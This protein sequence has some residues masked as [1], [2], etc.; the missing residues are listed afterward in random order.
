MSNTRPGPAQGPDSS[1]EA[2]H[3]EARAPL[4]PYEREEA[5]QREREEMIALQFDGTIT[6]V[7]VVRC[8]THCGRTLTLY[9]GITEEVTK[10]SAVAS[11]VRDG[12]H[13]RATVGWL[14]PVCHPLRAK[15]VREQK[16]ASI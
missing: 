15:T 1:K 11:F 14:C 16:G 13:H 9:P 10:S 5:Q 8:A 4:S 3:E 7:A 12:W 2:E 6:L